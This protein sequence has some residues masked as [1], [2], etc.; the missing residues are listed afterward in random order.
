MSGFGV[1]QMALN[2]LSDWSR[3]R[4]TGESSTAESRTSHKTWC[5]PPTGWV[6]INLDVACPPGCE[7]VA[8]GCVVRDEYGLFKRARSRI[9]TGARTSREAEAMSLREALSWIKG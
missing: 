4:T 7:Y 1:K 9:I 6:K 3:A 5:L 2:L 8:I